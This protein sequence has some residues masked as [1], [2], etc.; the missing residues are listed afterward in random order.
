MD[1]DT[2]WYR[3]RP[4][5]MRH[6]VRW[7]PAPPPKKGGSS[8]TF[9]FSCIVAKRL[10]GSRCH[11][12]IGHALLCVCVSVCLSVAA[13]LHQC[14]DPDVSWKNGRGAAQ[15]CT[16]GGFA[17]SAGVSLLW[18]YSPNTKCQRVLVLTLCLVDLSISEY[19]IRTFV[20]F[21]STVETLNTPLAFAFA[22]IDLSYQN[23]LKAYCILFKLF[24]FNN[25]AHSKLTGGAPMSLNS[26]VVYC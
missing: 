9:F 4:R 2:T 22:D 17:I 12:Y 11:L 19:G 25:I 7:D 1:Q 5:P 23:V 24:V 6:C 26:V 20:T 16:I 3:G 14:M 8:P 13:F 10:D 15:L 18:Q 21:I